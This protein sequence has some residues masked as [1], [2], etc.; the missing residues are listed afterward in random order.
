VQQTHSS[1]DRSVDNWADA[2]AAVNLVLLE[3]ALVR[4]VNA[5]QDLGTLVPMRQDLQDIEAQGQTA[6]PQPDGTA[7]FRMTISWSGVNAMARS[8][9]KR[10]RRAPPRSPRGSHRLPGSVPQRHTAR[11]EVT[12]AHTFPNTCRRQHLLQPV[13]RRQF[14]QPPRGGRFSA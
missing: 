1:L 3:D 13:G 2:D 14:H 7:I 9:A 10:P 11:A 6:E 12:W 4:M 5:F 8:C